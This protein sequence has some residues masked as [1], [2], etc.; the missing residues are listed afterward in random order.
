MYPLADKLTYINDGRNRT[1]RDTGCYRILQS[2]IYLSP[3][4][5]VF[6]FGGVSGVNI[7]NQ[8]SGY[9]AGTYALGV[10]AVA[11][12][13]DVATGTYTVSSAG[14]VTVV[15][16]THQGSGYSTVA[17]A[18]TFPLGGGVN[19]AGTASV[20]LTDTFDV[21]NT[22]VLWGQS[23]VVQAY[24]PWTRF[25]AIYRFYVNRLGMPRVSSVYNNR[26]IYLA[27]IPDQMY[28]AELDTVVKP[29]PI[30]DATTVE[31]IPFPFQQP[32][33]Y[34]AARKAKY[35]EQSYGE[36]EA[37]EKEYIA[38]AKAAIN[39]VFTRRIPSAYAMP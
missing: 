13:T 28:T 12:V 19:A 14:K 3:N 20:I 21:V 34:W 36:A 16:I 35:N 10:G 39:S 33:A 9:A 6:N 7:T 2:P 26:S 23:R 8:G 24:L 18:I 29:P 38:Q 25:N 37:F 22:T 30:V 17:P 11:G 32:V 1:V 5:E 31:V 4:V 27:P 15:T